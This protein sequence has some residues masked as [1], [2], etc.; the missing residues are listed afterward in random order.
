MLCAPF[1][2]IGLEVSILG[3]SIFG[4]AVY[5]NFTGSVLGSVYCGIATYQ[6]ILIMAACVFVFLF[7]QTWAIVFFDWDL[8]LFISRT[9]LVGFAAALAAAVATLILGGLENGVGDQGPTELIVWKGLPDAYAPVAFL[10]AVSLFMFPLHSS[11]ARPRR[12][13]R[14][15]AAGY[16][17]AF[18][19]N[20]LFGLLGYAIFGP[21]VQAIAINSLSPGAASKAIQILLSVDIFMT[22][23]VVIVP[24]SRSLK[25][26]MSSC[27]GPIKHLLEI[28]G[29]L[30]RT[31]G[32]MLF[33]GLPP[34][35]ILLGCTLLAIFVPDVGDLQSLT[36][37]I[38]LTFS[39]FVA[40]IV[41]H[42]KLRPSTSPASNVFSFIFHGLILLVGSVGGG[43]ALYKTILSLVETYSNGVG[44]LFGS[45][46]V[47]NVTA[48]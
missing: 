38:G 20:I 19:F 37:A 7:L 30:P 46:C 16:G 44:N 33:T 35:I 12:F 5:L 1:L 32:T 22:L 4:C 6:Y 23:L 24:S 14:A 39:A 18:I 10:F 9:S 2:Y 45:A 31:A 13:S 15:M 26:M 29:P 41:L 43:Y 25:Y 48:F 3:A 28:D 36:A 8:S 11:A 40:P 42:L 21:T 17:M 27:V 47:S 34:L